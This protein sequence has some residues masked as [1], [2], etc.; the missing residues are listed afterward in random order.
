M[1]NRFL[2]TD[3]KVYYS[4]HSTERTIIYTQESYWTSN[5][6]AICY[7]TQKKRKNLSQNLKHPQSIRSFTWFH[8]NW[9]MHKAY[10]K[11]EK[12]TIKSE[13]MVYAL[14]WSHG[15]NFDMWYINVKRTLR[16]KIKWQ[17]VLKLPFMLFKIRTKFS[18]ISTQS[19][20]YYNKA[21]SS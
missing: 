4:H 18:T 9:K 15:H 11:C 13:T 1:V 19:N 5:H 14:P 6:P 8:K 3:L 12:L 7:K 17:K 20:V 21:D 2:A 16:K 10:G